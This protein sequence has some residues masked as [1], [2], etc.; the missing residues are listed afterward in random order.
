MAVGI[1]KFAVF[2]MQKNR[3]SKSFVVVGRLKLI[4]NKNMPSNLRYS[5]SYNSPN[6]I[7]YVLMAIA[8]Q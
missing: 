6:A 1:H 2:S 4:E 5:L 8:G 7:R 3:V